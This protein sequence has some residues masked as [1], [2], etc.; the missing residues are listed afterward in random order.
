MLHIDCL[1]RTDF[2][3]YLLGSTL[4]PIGA[5][6][7]DSFY[8]LGRMAFMG[9]RFLDGESFEWFIIFL[10]FVT[11]TTALHLFKSFSCIEFDDDGVRV[12]YL[13]AE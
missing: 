3:T 4:V 1:G 2:V 12:S 9:G 10:Y 5:F 7:L 13:H 8:Q 6:L 11:P